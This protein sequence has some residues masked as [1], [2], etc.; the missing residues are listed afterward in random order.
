MSTFNIIQQKLEEFIKKYYTNELIKGAILFFAIGLLYLLIT[1]LVEYFLWLNPLG[2]RVLFW[3][4][5]I[6]ELGLFVRFI[7][8]PLAKLFKLQKGIDYKEASKIIGN[9]FPEVNDK[10]LNVLQLKEESS[11][12]DLLLA[13]IEQKSSELQPIPFKLAV[14]FKSNLKYLKYAAI[15]VVILVLTFIT[16]HFNWFSDSYER[17][18]NYK[19]AYEPPAPFQFFILNETLNTNENKDFKL[20]VAT[21]GDVVPE[22]VKISFNN[23]SYVLQQLS[24]GNFEYVFS[25][26]KSD[27]EFDLSAAGVR[28]KSY[29]LNVVEV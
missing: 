11:E 8:F 14:N 7:A 5:V 16:G 2:R 22:T 13:S 20:L 19:T 27:V 17:V 6:V 29:V 18:V 12:S 9:H 26:P 1:L 23:Q 21:V 3:A 10:L 25:R 24:P 28:S 15:P 4:F